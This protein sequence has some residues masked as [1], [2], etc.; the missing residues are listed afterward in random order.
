M[1]KPLNKK[2][3]FPMSGHGSNIDSW[4]KRSRFSP[5]R[6]KATFME[7]VV[8]FGIILVFA[9]VAFMGVSPILFGTGGFGPERVVTVTVERLYV[10]HNGH[11]SS[12]MVG[13]DEGVFEVDNGWMLGIYNADEVY[14]SLKEGHTYRVVTKGNKVVNPWIQEYPYIVD[15]SQVK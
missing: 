9:T 4:H 10:D 12:Y 14:S 3:D 11:N 7:Y 1:L 6:Y 5:Y 2:T 13:T 15:V 8:C